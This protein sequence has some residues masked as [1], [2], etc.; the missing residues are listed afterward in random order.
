VPTETVY[1]ALGSNIGDSITIVEQ[2][3]EALFERSFG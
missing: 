1:I 3:I 2:A